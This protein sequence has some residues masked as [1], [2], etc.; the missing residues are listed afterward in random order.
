MLRYVL[1]WSVTLY[2]ADPEAAG[3]GHKRISK[4]FVLWRECEDERLRLVVLAH[5]GRTRC[6][7]TDELMLVTQ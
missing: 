5:K 2:Y 6:D 3:R 4:Y 7:F 1:G